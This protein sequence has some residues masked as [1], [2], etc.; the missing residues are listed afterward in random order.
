M[1][2][3][4]LILTPVRKELNLNMEKEKTM[5]KTQ[6]QNHNLIKIKSLLFL[7]LRGKAGKNMTRAKYIAEAI[8]GN[9]DS[10]YVLLGR[11]RGWRYIECFATKPY[12]YSI[13]REGLRY[14]SK[15][16]AWY[17]G[18]VEALTQEIA[19]QSR[20][21]FWSQKENKNL[22]AE[23]EPVYYLQAPFQTADDFIKAEVPK[24][25]SW[26]FDG[27]PLLVVKFPGIVA[28][29]NSLPEWG[30]TRGKAMGQA[31][32]DSGIMKWD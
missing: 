22:Y 18:D 5:A 4:S 28:A 30:L 23:P 32:V 1:L 27:N 7:Q 2:V 14:L 3:N 13:G 21:I 8:D 24:G 20:M 10:L 6:H 25:N 11:W 16:D 15:V 19:L 29:W 9:V 17:P 26:Q 31:I 12:T